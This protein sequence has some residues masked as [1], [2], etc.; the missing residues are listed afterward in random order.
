MLKAELIG[1]LGADAEIKNG[2]GYSFVSMSG[3][4]REMARMKTVASILT[5]TGLMSFGTRPIRH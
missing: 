4:H 3:Q 5:R 2:E 1:N